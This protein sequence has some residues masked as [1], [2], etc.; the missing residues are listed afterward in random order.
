MRWRESRCY[1]K[2]IQK[3]RGIPER[4]KGYETAAGSPEK[5]V[6]L[7]FYAG[8][9]Y[10]FLGEYQKAEPLLAT[11]QKYGGNHALLAN[12]KAWRVFCCNQMNKKIKLDADPGKIDQ[13]EKTIKDFKVTAK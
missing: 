8:V 6:E 4:Y 12:I 7:N 1:E 9:S 13:I 2:A 3:L 10:A 11:A 5:S